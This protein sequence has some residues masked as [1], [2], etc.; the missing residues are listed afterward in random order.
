[1]GRRFDEYKLKNTKMRIKS[2]YVSEENDISPWEVSNFTSKI[3]TCIYKTDL[4]NSIAMAVKM[5][6]NCENILILDHP[7]KVEHKFSNISEWDLNTSDINTM[8]SIGRPISLKPCRR[9]VELNLLFELLEGMNQV[10]YKRIRRK[11]TTEDQIKAY[12]MLVLDGYEEAAQFV[13]EATMEKMVLQGLRFESEW[14]QN[15]IAD[16]KKKHS[17]YLK[18]E[19]TL[20]ELYFKIICKQTNIREIEKK[21]IQ[22]YYHRFYEYLQKLSRPIVGIYYKENN[23]IKV[24]CSDYFEKSSDHNTKI[25]FKNISDNQHKNCVIE[26]GLAARFFVSDEEKSDEIL[27]LEKQKLELEVTSKN[28]MK[29]VDRIQMYQMEIDYRRQMNEAVEA[30]QMKGLKGLFESYEKDR[31]TEL[32]DKTF[33]QYKAILKNGKYMIKD[34]MRTDFQ[35]LIESDKRKM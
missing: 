20:E 21:L 16:N 5:G 15:I 8:F 35:D 23:K 29:D 9:V 26:S 10:L 27:N 28:I 1:M 18:D 14:L 33:M 2:E 19:T 24:M 4:I 25:Y 31:L 12:Q 13:Y 17:N 32:Y 6:I 30:E 34:Q 11:L 7:L 3:S 22:K